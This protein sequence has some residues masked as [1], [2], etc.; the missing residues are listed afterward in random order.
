MH[1]YQL[2]NGGLGPAIVRAVV[3]NAAYVLRGPRDDR[4][5]VICADDVIK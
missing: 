1:I 4:V 3:S 5:S 2:V